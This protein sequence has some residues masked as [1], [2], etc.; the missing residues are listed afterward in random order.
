MP[1]I[2]QIFFLPPMAVARLG[3]SDQPLDSFNWIEDPSL[4]GAGKTVIDPAVTLEV[5]QDGSVRPF[6][7]GTI[8]F[9]DG[10]LM[11]PTAPFLELWARVSGVQELQPLTTALLSQ[12]QAT[13]ANVSYTVT[14]ANRKAARRTGDEACA[15]TATIAVVGNDHAAH[16]LAASSIGPRPL[17]SPDRPIPLGSFQVIRPASAAEFNVNLDTLRVRY[18]PAR[19]EVYGAPGAVNGTDQ[20]TGRSFEMVPAVNRILN[21]DATWITYNADETRFDNPEPADTYD[22]A[23]DSTRQELSFGVVDDTC[24][25][26]I[27]AVVV[28]NSTVRL[29]AVAR[30]FCGPPDFAPD[31]RP[32]VSLADELIDRDPP[33]NET[34]ESLDDALQRVGD[35]FQRAYETAS[36]A[37]VDAMRDRSLSGQRA[38]PFAPA[39]TLNDSMT[40]RD[41]LF[42]QT[43]NLNS[44]PTT[45][46][47]LPYASVAHAVHEPLADL[48]D[49]ALFLRTN[50]DKVKRIVRPPFGAFSDLAESVDASA[51]P[52]PDHRDPRNDRDNLFDMR[53][54]PYMRDA[55][56]S[57]LSITRRQYRTLMDVVQR[58]Q[59]QPAA[60]VSGAAPV[61]D[62]APAAEPPQTPVRKH[63]RRVAKRR[64]L[65]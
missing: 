15:Y 26:I 23:D 24:D 3:G 36:L 45:H 43:E 29:S 12:N 11:R 35:F 9:R 17:V 8:Q 59:A 13:L 39:T 60:P 57:P 1:G 54:P 10:N 46:E 64:G 52:N 40:E 30:V 7:P 31:R 63:V 58:L 19:G 53:M 50:A 6:M 34:P 48:E 61:A 5:Q 37:N 44:R 55:D 18:T 28:V 16:P 14:A 22:G 42:D 2:Q 4:H 21:S 62:A 56:A 20:E 38:S 51:A 47:R 25:V 32:F 33:A 49:L 65:Q 41:P 27:E